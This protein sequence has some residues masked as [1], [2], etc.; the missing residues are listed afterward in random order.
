MWRTELR[1]S[2]RADDADRPSF[3]VRAGE[4]YGIAGVGGNGQ[5]ELAEALIGARGPLPAISGSKEPAMSPAAGRNTPRRG[6]AAIPA[7]RYAYALAGALS[8]ADNFAIAGVHAG[9]YGAPRW[10]TGAMRRDATKP[11]PPSTCRAFAA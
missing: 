3:F 7:D 10:S 8:I 1:S 4:I 6:L 5:A 11:S 9:R 2:R